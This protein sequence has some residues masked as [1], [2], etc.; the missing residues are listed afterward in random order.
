MLMSEMERFFRPE[1]INRVDDVIVFKPLNKDNLT[2]IVELECN[3]LTKRLADRKMTLVLDQKAK[4]FLI[5][6]GY[7]PDMG[8]RPLRRAISRYVENPLSESI[9]RG[10]ILEGYT[11]NVTH[12]NESPAL[13]FV[14][15]PGEE[16]KPAEDTI[17]EEKA[18]TENHLVFYNSYN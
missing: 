18:S 7:N 13:K 1:F 10:D 17:V 2:H 14:N 15:T 16:E 9:L 11:I 12:E 6:N 3:K 4:D 5:E 8:A